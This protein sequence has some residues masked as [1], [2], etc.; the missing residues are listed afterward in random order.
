[1]AVN[2][3]QSYAETLR[4]MRTTRM[5]Q[6]RQGNSQ[7]QIMN[8]QIATLTTMNN[9]LSKQAQMMSRMESSQ[10]A[11]NQQLVSVNRNLTN[12]S[13]T[14]SRSLSN[15]AA[16]VARG[17][18]SGV[19][20]AGG[21]VADT[22]GAAASATGSIA[23]SIASGIGR[24]L[25]VAIAGYVV[26]SISWDNMSQQT[27]DRLSGSVGKLF[28]KAMKEIDSTEIGNSLTKAL[29][30]AF[31]KISSLSKKLGE[32]IDAVKSKL[33]TAS[34]AKDTVVQ[35]AENV[36]STVASPG[37]QREIKRAEIIA[38][39][40]GDVAKS[41]ATT[42]YETGKAVYQNPGSVVSTAQNVLLGVGT[43]GIALGTYELAKSGQGNAG[44]VKMSPASQKA[45]QAL[46]SEGSK[47]TKINIALARTAQSMAASSGPAA[48][49]IMGLKK[50]KLKYP[51][52]FGPI[53]EAGMYYWL[54]TEID[55]MLK[56]GEL[57]KEEADYLKSDAQRA[58]AFRMAG[59]ATGSAT[60]A[61][62]A[63]GTTVAT[64]GFGA[65]L[66]TSMVLGG[67]YV[68]SKVGEALH[69]FTR[70][71][72]PASLYEEIKPGGKTQDI[73]NRRQAKTDSAAA[74]TGK[75][76][77]STTQPGAAGSPSIN[78]PL[79]F[80][81]AL[82]EKYRSAVGTT[83]GGAAGYDAVYGA[84]TKKGVEKYMAEETGGK[85]LTEMTI[86]EAI[87]WQAR[88]KKQGKNTHAFGRYQF[89]NLLKAAKKAGL[90]MN[91]L[92]SPKNQDR[93]FDAYT[94]GN[95]DEL[96]GNS[97]DP[98]T[99]KVYGPV[100]ATAVN[101]R[102]AHAVGALGA[103]KLLTANPNAVPADVL[104][105]TSKKVEGIETSAERLS[106]PQL[107]GTNRKGFENVTVSSY[108][109]YITNKT[110]NAMG[111]APV[112]VAQ[113][114]P[115]PAANS[116]DSPAA[117]TSTT[118]SVEKAQASQTA[119]STTTS[120]NKVTDQAAP[121]TA[122]KPVETEDQK[123]KRSIAEMFSGTLASLDPERLKSDL[124]EKL[125]IAKSVM[126]GSGGS[127]GTT[128]NNVDNSTNTSQSGGGSTSKSV[129]ADNS[130][131][132]FDH[133]T[134]MWGGRRT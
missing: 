25:P 83:E 49:F 115:P 84:G 18:G 19:R 27:R 118:T 82:F 5:Q 42:I 80:G 95:K 107:G 93:M 67:G 117:R 127:G 12:L 89:M 78:T 92:M 108:L 15:F 7:A 130:G 23:T 64:G 66:A 52:M 30:P 79:E 114:N 88:R 41:A 96:E 62:A 60:A 125:E 124:L 122:P 57:T 45:M 126:V 94:K 91:E 8:K 133:A 32:E 68:G 48:K 109:G 71:K 59:G 121:T 37:V 106:N 73:M 1:M 65:I 26:K 70:D 10:R 33:P 116:V 21:A 85:K 81:T 24:V 9:L 50:T 28:D 69:E 110:A 13:S 6:L 123:R 103:K 75:P 129:H 36:K 76:Q 3:N 61:V 44:G 128:I 54:S 111:A 46:K 72:G 29:T 2:T 31:D 17:A 39:D 58:A 98:V 102:L 77:A 16:T 43:T 134:T 105:L 113:N 97:V 87:E 112:T 99:K 56:L 86:G 4:E 90:S 63:G 11:S 119:S 40:V 131:S 53:L 120:D 51:A 35:T 34:Q 104:G 55:A 74:A 47:V 132:N 14:L 100:P 20:A 38:G 22:A 101:L